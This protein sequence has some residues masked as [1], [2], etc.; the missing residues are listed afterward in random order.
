MSNL[1]LDRRALLIAGA[2][3]ATTAAVAPFS[4]AAAGTVSKQVFRGGFDARTKRDW[5]YLPFDVPAG[6]RKITVRYKYP[7]P[8]DTGFGISQN[9]IDIGIFDPDGFRGW[10]G[11]ARRWFQL[12][13]TGATPGYLPGE[14]TPGRWRV[15]LG[16]Y[17]V[18]DPIRYRVVVTLHFGEP[19]PG[20]VPAPAPTAVDPIRPAGWY[21]G[22]LH[23]HTVHSDGSQTQGDVV[24]YAKAAGLD[25]IGT[26]EH[27]TTSATQTWGRFAPADFLVIPGAEVTTRAG[28]WLASGVPAGT[29]IDWRYTDDAKLAARTE[30]VRRLGG[31]AIAAHPNIPAPS[32]RWDFDSSFAQMDAIE[33][34]N[35]P[36]TG[37]NGVANNQA[38]T[39]WHDLLTAGIFKPAVGNSDTHRHGQ[40]IGLA[41]TVVRAEQL[42]VEA[43]I[44]GYR[45]GHSWLT[46][47]SGVDLQFTA[48]NADVSGECGDRVPSESGQEVD[49][50]LVVSGVPDCTA[51]L[52]G[53][54]ATTFGTATAV[55]GKITWD[56]KV[57]GGTAFV[58][59]EVRKG[60]AAN[61][62]M[63]AMTNPIFL[64]ALG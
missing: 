41:Q 3:V 28:H 7:E 55:D 60:T 1:H 12:S 15:A 38:V 50:R 43:I 56:V 44:E 11:G 2:G 61:S 51:T 18:V 4:P 16:P 5:H 25:F 53:P 9:V 30:Q 40:A 24:T 49:V 22:D 57:P 42:S 46:A 23:V 37:I 31:I 10:S 26:S 36:W 52:I 35:G 32:I 34:W 19:G 21:R 20:F 29:W 59:A 47:S 27:N 48:T 63:V 39:R 62:Q 14:I 8:K 13:R 58:R 6:V 33:V 64:T 54:G 17:Q 45:L